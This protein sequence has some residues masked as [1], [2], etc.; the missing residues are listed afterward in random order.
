ETTAELAVLFERLS[1]RVKAATEAPPALVVKL[2]PDLD[3]DELP[4]MV[5]AIEAA[6][7]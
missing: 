7:V 2:S 1:V 3:T 6:G 5:A 4:E